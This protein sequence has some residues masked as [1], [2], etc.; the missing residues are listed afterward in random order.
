MGTNLICPLIPLPKNALLQ[1][2][3][4]QMVIASDEIRTFV[5][6]NYARLNWTSS[7]EAGGL[8]GFGGK[9]AAMVTYKLTS[10]R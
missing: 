9:Q 10:G 3:T 4:F 8:N 1:Q 7:N 5:I 2:N 6:F